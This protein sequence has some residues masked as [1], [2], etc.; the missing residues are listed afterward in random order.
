MP[1]SSV[2]SPVPTSCSPFC[3]I[4]GHVM[5]GVAEGRVV[6]VT[7]EEMVTVNRNHL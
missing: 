5:V 7:G 3:G 2:I 1:G 4:G 6:S